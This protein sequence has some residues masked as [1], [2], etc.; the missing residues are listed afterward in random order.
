MAEES[1]VV[2]EATH[3]PEQEL[4]QNETVNVDAQS[5]GVNLNHEQITLS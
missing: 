4:G 3:G 1:L 2:V 5:T